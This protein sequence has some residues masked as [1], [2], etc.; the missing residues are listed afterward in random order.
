MPQATSNDGVKIHYEVEG[1]GP[2]L[3]LQHGFSG[4]LV[5][6]SDAGYVDALRSS[7]RLM[8]VDGRGHGQSDKPHDVESYAIRRRVDDVLAVLD[9]EGV[10]RSSYWGYSM[11]G[12]IG[13]GMLN[14]APDRLTAAV[15]GG[16][17]P[18]E[19]ERSQY[20]TRIESLGGR[21]EAYVAEREVQM[22][23]RV[24]ESRR[25]RLLANDPEAL[26]AATR[27]DL[28][29]DPPSD[30]LT[31]IATP[32][33]IFCGTADQYHDGAKRAAGEIPDAEFLSLDGIDH[34][35]AMQRSELVLPRAT[36][37]LAHAAER[38]PV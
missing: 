11:G 15:I 31:A 17:H 25:S 13:Y 28:Q 27:S 37:F 2:P 35:Q 8:L 29:E 6:W 9:A 20:E 34:G 19:R 32:T 4:S 23:S 36:E 22:G 24:P 30:R 18:Y 10:E 14:L 7:Y 5:G 21:M 12:R 3:L 1:D 16:M 38:T 33:F 26:A